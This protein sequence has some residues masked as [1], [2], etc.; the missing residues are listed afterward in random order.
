M[1]SVGQLFGT[2]HGLEAGECDVRGDE[3]DRGGEGNADG[4][5]QVLSLKAQQPAHSRPH[6]QGDTGQCGR[7]SQHG[8]R[9]ARE[10]EEVGHGE[11]IAGHGA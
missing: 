6:E 1:M 5:G 4:G 7:H 2:E 10:V 8:K 3:E 11:R 9:G